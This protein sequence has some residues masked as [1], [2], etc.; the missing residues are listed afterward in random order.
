[1]SEPKFV[2]IKCLAEVALVGEKVMQRGETRRVPAIIAA[3]YAARH[4]NAIEVVND[5]GSAIVK[6]GA[7]EEGSNPPAGD[8]DAAA[9][10]AAAAAA[11]AGG[12]GKL[13]DLQPGGGATPTKGK[14]S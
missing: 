4:P 5:D 7:L 9:K 14:K 11:A 6:A 8:P 13:A 12:D 3:T 2:T 10:A 1:M